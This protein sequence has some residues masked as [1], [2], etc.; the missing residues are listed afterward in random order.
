[1]HACMAMDR[2]SPRSIMGTRTPHRGRKGET[3]THETLGEAPFI[4]SKSHAT[5]RKDKNDG[6][7]VSPTFNSTTRDRPRTSNLEPVALR[8]GQSGQ[9]TN[10]SSQ[11]IPTHTLKKQ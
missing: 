8:V 3:T 11:V 9:M 10:K 5:E 4:D 7:A 2:P 6:S 1:M